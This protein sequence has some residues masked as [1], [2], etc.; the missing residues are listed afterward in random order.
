MN[1]V[2]S[3][4]L[5]CYNAISPHLVLNVEVSDWRE[6]MVLSGGILSIGC[7]FNIVTRL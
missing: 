3:K 1:K 2:C 4:D 5:N 7:T 6:Q